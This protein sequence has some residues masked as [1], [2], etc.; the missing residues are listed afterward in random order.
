VK[1]ASRVLDIS[2]KI[3]DK[4]SKVKGKVNIIENSCQ[5]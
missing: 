3:S 5:G 2:N 4:K 1:K